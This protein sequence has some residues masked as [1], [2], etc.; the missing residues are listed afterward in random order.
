VRDIG[1][2]AGKFDIGRTAV[3]L[4]RPVRVTVAVE[5]RSSLSIERVVAETESALRFYAERY[6]DYPWTTYKVVVLSDPRKVF[7][8]NS[9]L[10]TFIG[11]R[12]AVLIPHETAHQW[13]Y[14]LVGNDQARDPWI[15][16]GLTTWAQTG[17]EASFTRT[18]AT[19]IPVAL[20]NR[21]GEPMSFWDGLGFEKTRLG[22][23]I[24]S[25]QA[26]ASLGDQSAVDCA[27]RLFVVRNA[28]RTATPRDLL[29][30]LL[31]FFPEAEQ[32]LAVYGARF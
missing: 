22:V 28:Y 1:V 16:E 25:V 21:I 20:R 3:R 10:M 19:P 18:V 13:F 27:L 2:V 15:S 4:P 30:A 12:S 14:S 17:P 8:N 11:D 32:K 23:H 26:L 24:Q 7:G 29:A 6:G 9:P 31:E 5:R